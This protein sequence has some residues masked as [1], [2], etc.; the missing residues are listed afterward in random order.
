[1][2]C[3]S[4]SSECTDNNEEEYQYKRHQFRC[5]FLLPSLNSQDNHSSGLT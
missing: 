3:D 2:P 5:G 1:M 4:N